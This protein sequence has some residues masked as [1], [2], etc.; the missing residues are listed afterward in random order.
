MALLRFTGKRATKLRP[1]LCAVHWLIDFATAFMYAVVR[2]ILRY[3]QTPGSLLAH[4]PE[5]RPGDDVTSGWTP[6][7]KLSP[8]RRFVRS[9]L[10]NGHR[11]S[12]SVRGDKFIIRLDIILEFRIIYDAIGRVQATILRTRCVHLRIK[13]STP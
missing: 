9:H 2:W 4:P 13:D 5:P 6:A 12:D 7:K 8:P 1:A 10:R 3:T 11:L